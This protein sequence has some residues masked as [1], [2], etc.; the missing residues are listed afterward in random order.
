MRCQSCEQ[1]SH[2][3]LASLDSPG[4]LPTPI[5]GAVYPGGPDRFSGIPLKPAPTC[6][7]T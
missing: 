5:P 7:K 4:E 6:A 1:D 3:L 2:L